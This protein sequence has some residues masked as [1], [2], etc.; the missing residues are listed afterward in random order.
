MFVVFYFLFDLHTHISIHYYVFKELRSCYR[1][2]PLVGVR[3]AANRL[4]LIFFAV[5][6]TPILA[7]IFCLNL[8]LIVDKS[9]DEDFKL[10]VYIMTEAFTIMV[11][12]ITIAK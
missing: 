6:R 2:Q 3:A 7:I 10:N 12:C 5:Y 8:A 1:D 11:Y 4:G 9:H